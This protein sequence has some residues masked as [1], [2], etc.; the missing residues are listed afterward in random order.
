[1]LYIIII[2]ILFLLLSVFDVKTVLKRY[3]RIVLRCFR[4]SPYAVY[5]RINGT[6][7]L[8][9]YSW[10]IS[11]CTSHTWS[12]SPQWPSTERKGRYD[13]TKPLSNSKHHS[14]CLSLRTKLKTKLF[15]CSH[16]FPLKTP[17]LT[18]SAASVNSS[19]SLEPCGSS[20]KLWESR[21]WCN[22]SQKLWHISFQ[23][24]LNYPYV[25]ISISIDI[26]F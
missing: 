14:L 11:W 15:T 17:R 26:S 16:R 6:G 10:W 20:T 25:L 23:S 5:S 7:L 9:N 1:M 24:I 18:A 21:I 19:V 3:P 4:S 22:T 12:S 8:P 13:P 2:I